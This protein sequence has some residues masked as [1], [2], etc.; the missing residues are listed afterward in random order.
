MN[1]YQ[2]ALQAFLSFAADFTEQWNDR[3][4]KLP[5]SWNPNMPFDK[6]VTIVL[7]G[8]TARG[9]EHPNDL[10]VFVVAH[11]VL[12]EAMG[13]HD[14]SSYIPY[15]GRTKKAPGIW[16]LQK[17][18]FDVNYR[19]AGWKLDLF[20]LPQSYFTDDAVRTRYAGMQRDPRFYENVFADCKVFDPETGELE[21]SSFEELAQR[22]QMAYA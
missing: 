1:K 20:V 17:A 7:F 16:T 12:K 6:R 8:S 5:H 21:D 22:F 3:I 14:E 4:P 2:T 19:F 10:D 9:K 15:V 13:L 11:P 18:G